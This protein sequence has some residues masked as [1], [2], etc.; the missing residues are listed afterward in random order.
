MTIPMMGKP[1]SRCQ[2]GRAGSPVWVR[3]PAVHTGARSTRRPLARPDPAGYPSLAPRDRA[4]A[5][6]GSMKSK[7]VGLLI[8]LVTSV[9]LG[10]LLGNVFFALF[11]KTVPAAVL[12][13]FNKSTAHLAFIAYGLGA[14][15]L[16]FVWSVVAIQVS[17]F[18]RG[19]PRP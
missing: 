12:T 11:E 15:V 16:I 2:G 6:G 7:L 5:P 13:S 3:E 17:R 9:G 18:F 14:G 4:I 19:R 8:L 1:R 10:G